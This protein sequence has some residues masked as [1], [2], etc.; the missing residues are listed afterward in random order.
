MMLLFDQNISPRLTKVRSDIIPGSLHVREIGLQSADDAN[1]WDYAAD[2]GFV[3]A[4]K[5][6]DFH[7]RS[8]L[9]GHPQKT[10]WIRRGNCPTSE[11][12]AI[13]RKH[14][15]DLQEFERDEQGSFLALG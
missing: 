9:F 8:F 15:S 5:D 2:H 13:L 3:I 12:E 11:I 6:S 14:Y 4:S 10:V 1:I 7:Q